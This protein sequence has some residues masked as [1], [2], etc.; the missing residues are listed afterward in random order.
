MTASA[1]CELYYWPDIPGRGEFVRLVL[2]TAGV[3]YR[4][5]GAE[6][7]I[8]AV[9]AVTGAMGARGARMP[10]APPVLKVGDEMIWHTAHICAYLAE[11]HGLAPDTEADRRFALSLALTLEDFVGEIH[12]THHPIASGQY[13]EQQREA[14]LQRAADF[15]DRRAGQF[16]GYFDAQ[17]Q[18][19]GSD[20]LVGDRLTYVD[21]SLFQIAEGLAYA[22]PNACSGWAQAFVAVAAHRRRV[23]NVPAVAA[24]LNSERRRGFNQAGIFRH[25][26]ELDAPG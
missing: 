1:F 3:A 13:Y 2:E 16:L 23:G 5:V 17:L 19:N 8:E 18:A 24:Y 15:R 21:L 6:D 26:P 25:Y 20:W 14:A 10:F 7:G 22:F 11:R 12:D 4:D 9:L